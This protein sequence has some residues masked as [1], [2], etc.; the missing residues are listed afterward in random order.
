MGWMGLVGNHQQ[1]FR[2]GGWC[3]GGSDGSDS[4]VRCDIGIFGGL[5]DSMTSLKYHLPAAGKE[6]SR[7]IS[8]T[9]TKSK[10]RKSSALVLLRLR[11]RRTRPLITYWGL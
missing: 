10:N 2:L 9:K 11:R 5:P 4:S 8:F 1:S 6:I 3:L 7:K